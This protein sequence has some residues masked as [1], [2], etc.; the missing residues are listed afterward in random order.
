MAMSKV[1]KDRFECFGV[2]FIAEAES[3]CKAL[4]GLLISPLLIINHSHFIKD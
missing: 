1:D 2:A 4:P 3:V